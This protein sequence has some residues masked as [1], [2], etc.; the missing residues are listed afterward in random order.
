VAEHVVHPLEEALSLLLPPPIPEAEI[1]FSKSLFLQVLQD[2]FFS[3]PT[4][5]SASKRAPHFL[6]K[7]S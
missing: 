6:H 5:T 1:N 7:N 2:T 4:E 3:P